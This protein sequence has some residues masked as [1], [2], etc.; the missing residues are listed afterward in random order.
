[1]D[2]G[3]TAAGDAG[4]TV[5]EVQQRQRC[6]QEK[7][8]LAERLG[9]EAAL[10]AAVDLL[11]AKITVDPELKRFFDKIP[12]PVLK[13]KQVG[14]LYMRCAVI[15]RRFAALRSSQTARLPSADS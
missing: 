14:F 15:T 1:L 9:G 4:G 8:S 2:D 10:A 5:R 11:Y 3:D 6:Q 13:R 7:P 12:L